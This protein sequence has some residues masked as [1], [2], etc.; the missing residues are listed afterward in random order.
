MENV[1]MEVHTLCGGSSAV[2]KMRVPCQGSDHGLF[3]V[4]GR[5]CHKQ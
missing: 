2:G 1:E 5:D 3:V 4:K